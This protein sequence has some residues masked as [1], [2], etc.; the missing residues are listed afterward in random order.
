MGLAGPLGGLTV[1]TIG[2]MDAPADSVDVPVLA[3]HERRLSGLDRLLPARHPLPERLPGDTLLTVDGGLALARSQRHDPHTLAS[4]WASARA[5]QLFPRVG[6]DSPA[7]T[8]AALLARWR[9]V[10]AAEDTGEDGDSEAVLR[11][12]SRDPVMTHVFRAYGLAPLTVVAARPA[13]APV[14]VPAGPVTVRPLAAADLAVAVDLWRALVAYDGQFGTM[15][16]R[17]STAGLLREQLAGALVRQPSWAWVAELDG[18]VCGLLVADPP[19]RTGWV[20]PLVGAA[21]VAYVGA[22]Y[23]AEGRRGAGVGA[24]LVRH[25]HSVFDA[26]GV[27]VTLLHYAGFSPL[28]G[29]FWHRHGYRPLWTFWLAHPAARLG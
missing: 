24:A 2:R 7:A 25:A 22:M 1:A 28:S 3:A 4:T 20:S 13:H 17:P 6:G 21:P 18:E 9:R 14:A 23:V 5:F 19:Q 11:W 29:P 27:A 16:E 8:M 26:A 15:R 12:P 10:V